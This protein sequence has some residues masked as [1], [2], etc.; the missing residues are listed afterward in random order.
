MGYARVNFERAAT[1]NVGASF[2]LGPVRVYMRTIRQAEKRCNE[3][4]QRA[5]NP[6]R[7]VISRI[8]QSVMVKVVP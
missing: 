3:L 2:E 4:R 7:V 1:M 5:G 6:G 8:G